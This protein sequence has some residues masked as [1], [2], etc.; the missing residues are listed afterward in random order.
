MSRSPWIPFLAA[1]AAGSA[2]TL[3]GSLQPWPWL[4]PV[5]VTA[6]VYPIFYTGVV[7]GRLGRTVGVMLVWAIAAT[8]T[9]WTIAAIGGTEPLADRVIQGPAYAAEM[10]HWKETGIGAEGSPRQ[11][12]PLHARHFSL[13]CVAS[14]ITGGAAG[15][16]FGVVL[17]DYMN[18]YVAELARS[19]DNVGAFLIGW[20]VWA[21]VRVVGF[22][23][24]GTA[25]AHLFFG[26]IWIRG[27]WDPMAFRR[28]MLVGVGLVVL[29]ALLK[30]T[31]AE[32]WRGFLSR[33]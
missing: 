21:V 31:L 9:F 2:G 7:R 12:L 4:W 25:L 16:A 3:L 11:F 8:W 29:D 32:T 6:L 15:L 24:A 14:V 30:S 17:L 27:S 20:P 26:R 23:S 5:V 10:L 13:F 1:A 22:M 19:T 18:F 33:L 28:W